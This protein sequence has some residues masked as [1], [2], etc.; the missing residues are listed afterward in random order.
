MPDTAFG[1][2]GLYILS[3]EARTKGVGLSGGSKGGEHQKSAAT[4]VGW[5]EH[6]AMGFL[7]K[8]KT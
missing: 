7:R 6:A 3:D 4:P 5:G 1:T 2:T 8:F